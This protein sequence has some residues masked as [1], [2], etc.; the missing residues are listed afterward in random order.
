MK[1]I[2][3][4]LLLCIVLLANCASP[5]TVRA[6]GPLW[7]FVMVGQSNGQF[8]CPY[9]E[10]SIHAYYGTDARLIC[11]AIPGSVIA[12][13]QPGQ[14]D[15]SDAVIAVR[16]AQFDGY[17]LKAI[18]MNHGE[19]DGWYASASTYGAQMANFLD[20]FKLEIGPPYPFVFY[21]QLGRRPSCAEQNYVGYPYWETIRLQ[22]HN[23]RY[24]RPSWKMIEESPFSAE[25]VPGLPC[26]HFNA[27][28]LQAIAN[29]YMIYLRGWV[30]VP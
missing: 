16:T 21:S 2:L 15:Y 11:A 4:I 12:D 29:Q 26:A 30:P 13:W 19:T 20:S 24:N 18:L 23:V 14:Q 25:Y 3:S 17:T 7:S 27:T 22:Q 9:L 5:A 8:L 6:N 10:T 28:E 1:K